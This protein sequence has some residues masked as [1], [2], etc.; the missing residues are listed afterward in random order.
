MQK[1]VAS[2]RAK[3]VG[4]SNFGITHLEKLAADS[5]TKITPAVN[6]IELHPCNPS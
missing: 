2:G 3:N 1:L 4:V 6:Q 5:R